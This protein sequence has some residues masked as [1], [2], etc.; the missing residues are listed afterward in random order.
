MLKC[1]FLASG[2]KINLYKSN[3][4]GIGINTREV[5]CAARLVGCSTFTTLVNSLGVKVGDVMSRIKSWYKVDFEKAFDSVRWDYLDDVLKSFC[6]GANGVVRL[7]VVSFLQWVLSSLMFV[8]IIPFFYA[9]DVIFVS[10]WDVYDIKT[11]IRMLKCFF[12]ASGLKINLYKSNLMG[13]GINTREV[14]CAARLVGCSTFTT[15]VNYLGVKVED[16]MSRIKSWYKAWF[17]KAIYGGKGAF[18]NVVVPHHRNQTMF[19]NALLRRDIL[20]DDIVRVSYTWCASRC[21]YNF[22]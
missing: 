9:D 11:L 18:D 14:A 6:F 13:I 19:G 22:D 2:L 20:F 1:F 21:K 5:E 4:M 8:D 16:V 17:I 15:L 12:L 3:L 7:M 10:E